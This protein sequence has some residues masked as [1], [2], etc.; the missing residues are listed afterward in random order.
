MT[1]V[2]YVHWSYDLHVARRLIVAYCSYGEVCFDGVESVLKIRSHCI[3]VGDHAADVANDRRYDEY[4]AEKVDYDERELGVGLRSRNF[5]DRHQHHCRP[6]ETATTAASA[7]RNA[8]ARGRA[9]HCSL[10]HFC[11]KFQN[12]DSD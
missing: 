6:V 1:Y 10:T 11:P 8:L 2:L 7:N 4:S 9:D 12:G 5:A 3:R